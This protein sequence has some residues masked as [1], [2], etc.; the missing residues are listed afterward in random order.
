[1]ALI[2]LSLLSLLVLFAYRQ[3]HQGQ[4]RTTG[5]RESMSGSLRG[6]HRRDRRKSYDTYDQRASYDSGYHDDIHR[7]ID[8]NTAASRPA[9]V[10][11]RDTA[12]Y[13]DHTRRFP[14]AVNGAHTAREAPGTVRCPVQLNTAGYPAPVRARDTEHP[15][16]N[17]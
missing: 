3:R 15:V 8:L 6:S 11:G 1:M 13:L 2:F 14:S 5:K 10:V 17:P 16:R 12:D 4:P 9:A 7:G